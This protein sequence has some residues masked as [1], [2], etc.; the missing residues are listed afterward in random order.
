MSISNLLQKNDYDIYMGSVDLTDLIITNPADD[1]DYVTL[2]VNNNNALVIER[3]N[4]YAEGIQFSTDSDQGVLNYYSTL[5]TSEAN[6][7]VVETPLGGTINL[8]PSSIKIVRIGNVVTIDLPNSLTV[9]FPNTAPYGGISTPFQL[10]A[11]LPARFRPSNDVSCVYGYVTTNDAFISSEVSISSA[12]IITWY[13]RPAATG[14]PGVWDS[15]TTASDV[16][17][18]RSCF[19]YVI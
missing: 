3:G 9:N 1:A 11:G 13:P 18:Y 12:G 8:T 19:S 7:L 16:D 17:V 4:L 15:A 6:A 14:L 2:T 10:Q 5:S